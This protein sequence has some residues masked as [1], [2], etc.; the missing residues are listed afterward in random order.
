MHNGILMLIMGLR[1]AVLDQVHAEDVLH[2]KRHLSLCIVTLQALHSTIF[3]DKSHRVS[4]RSESDGSGNPARS[5]ESKPPEISIML[6][7]P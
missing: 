3:L 4:G 7:P 1:L 2:G 6:Q 5:S